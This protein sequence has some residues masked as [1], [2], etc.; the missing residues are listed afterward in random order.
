MRAEQSVQVQCLRR[1]HVQHTHCSF[2]QAVAL[3]SLR[4]SKCPGDAQ[5]CAPPAKGLLMCGRFTVKATWTEIVA[6]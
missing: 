2:R 4:Q 3:P 1:G 6:L 5:A